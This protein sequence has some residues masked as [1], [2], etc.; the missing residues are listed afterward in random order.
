LVPRFA[1]FLDALTMALIL[2]DVILSAGYVFTTPYLIWTNPC[3]PHFTA[4]ASLLVSSDVCG[5]SI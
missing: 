1:Y 3:D 5:S 2:A 4:N